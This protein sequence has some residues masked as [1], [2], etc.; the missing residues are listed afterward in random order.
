MEEVSVLMPLRLS[1][2]ELDAVRRDPL[3]SFCDMD[4]M[5]KRIGWLICA[6]DAIVKQR[7]SVTNPAPDN[8]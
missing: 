5:N 4:E 8:S 2:N 1:A 3:C 6:Y 7:I